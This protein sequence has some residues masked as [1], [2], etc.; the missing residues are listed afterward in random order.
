MTKL[1]GLFK[2]KLFYAVKIRHRAVNVKF[3]FFVHFLQSIF[4]FFF[5]LK[6]RSEPAFLCNPFIRRRQDFE[7]FWLISA[8]IFRIGSLVP[9]GIFSREAMVLENL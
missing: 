8:I 5:S 9:S 7:N 2:S 3:D 1:C 4:Q 6:R